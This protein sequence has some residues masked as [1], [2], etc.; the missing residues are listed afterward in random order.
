M[1]GEQKT[2][3]LYQNIAEELSYKALPSEWTMINLSTFSSDISLFD[4]QQEA[5]KNATKLLYYYFCS[6]QKFQEGE[7]SRLQFLR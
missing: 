1:P 7:D 6:L 2:P 4:Y 5:I 3:L